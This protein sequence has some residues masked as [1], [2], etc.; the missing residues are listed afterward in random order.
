MFETIEQAKRE[1]R[2]KRIHRITPHP[3][4]SVIIFND[5][6]SNSDSAYCNNI[7]LLQIIKFLVYSHQLHSKYYRKSIIITRYFR[8]WK[9]LN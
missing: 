2:N 5:N 8:I 3:K 6:S 7:F 4:K 1:H 9:H